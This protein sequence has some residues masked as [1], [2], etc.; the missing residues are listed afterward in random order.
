[1]ALLKLSAREAMENRRQSLPGWGRRGEVNR[2]EPLALPWFNAPFQLEAGDSIYVTGSCSARG[3]EA[4]LYRRGFHTP[5]RELFEQED[6][7]NISRAV[8]NN[9]GVASV[10]NE[11]GWALD[12]NTPYDFDRNILEVEPGLWADLHVAPS[13]KPRPRTEV[14]AWRKAVI[15]VSRAVR[16]C[17][18]VIM[19]FGQNELW[20]D[21]EQQL[22]LNTPPHFALLDRFPDRFEWH[23]LDFDQTRGFIQRA[24]DL[25]KA[26]SRPDQQIL[27]A[28]APGPLHFTLRPDDVMVANSY[29]K[30]CL[31]SA[32]EHVCMLNDAVHYYPHFEAVSLSDRQQAWEDDLVHVRPG[33]VEASANRLTQA[34]LAEADD[35]SALLARAER[36]DL[37]GLEERAAGLTAQSV[38]EG[39]R[40]FDQVAPF[41]Q[42]SA[43][44]AELAAQH[45]LRRRDVVSA[46][47]QVDFLP[48]G[49]DMARKLLEARVL[50]AE[51]RHDA[52]ADL[53]TP[54][55]GTSSKHPLRYWTTL[56]GALA[57]GGR[58]DAAWAA[59]MKWSRI[60]S[61]RRTVA[62]T[63]FAR[64][65][66]A[67]APSAAADAFAAVLRE[68]EAPDWS[69]RA[70]LVEA[71]LLAGRRD[72]ACAQLDQMHPASH[73]ERAGLVRLRGLL[74]R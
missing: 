28:V 19:M 61:R 35:L 2:V 43:R 11:F 22:Y 65:A 69:L 66:M 15:E 45:F 68:T 37:T 5:A 71:L 25:L 42:K 39:T 74:G 29:S 4:A 34:I 36:G 41:G 14:V 49:E 21:T 51:G 23:V 67:T 26:H 32:V 46:R 3:F 20:F 30:A 52:A 70:S 27:L 56:V 58:T 50:H 40:F 18:L 63:T 54:L 24:I 59:V 53:L 16:D 10:A 38:G 33:I 48:P 8:M 62:L 64:A 9:Y 12:P 1:M 73:G 13:T 47:Q 72:E 44:L 55:A 17:R 7:R 60:D 31:R 6:F 57:A